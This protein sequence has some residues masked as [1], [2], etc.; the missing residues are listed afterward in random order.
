[1]GT[2]HKKYYYRLRQDSER[3]QNFS[4][5]IRK[6]MDCERAAYDLAESL[7][8][9]EYIQSPFCDFGR[10]SAFRFQDAG[11]AKDR[12]FVKIHDSDLYVPDVDL[13]FTLHKKGEEP[14]GPD[15][16][17]KREEIDYPTAR[18]RFSRTEIA[19]A[20]HIRL[21]YLSPT[22]YLRLLKVAPDYIGAYKHGVMNAAE[23]LSK[24]TIKN[25]RDKALKVFFL[26]AEKEETALGAMASTIP[27][28]ST[29]WCHGTD[30]GKAVYYAM[31][32]LPAVP[33][34]TLNTIAG[35]PVN[36]SC[37]AFTISEGWIYIKASAPSILEKTLPTNDFQVIG[38]KQW[39]DAVANE[40][41][42][43]QSDE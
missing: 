12:G 24:A 20:L 9:E 30:K 3:G 36:V 38:E 5:I 1:M 25:R 31:R 4:D 39:E 17:L 35:I 14:N 43:T 41:N 22:E 29:K 40:K 26:K 27:F 23:V 34:G 37:V 7:G 10:C 28:I 13:R 16:L 2:E 6:G 21:E 33:V 19:Q 8:A 11:L 32:E 15:M 42:H 18:A